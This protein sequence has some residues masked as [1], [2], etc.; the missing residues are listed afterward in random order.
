MEHLLLSFNVIFP[1]FLLMALGY[2]I[3]RTGLTNAVTLDQMNDVS[4]KVFFPVLLFNSI[5]HTD[6][7]GA[8]QP[9]LFLFGVGSVLLEFF[10]LMLIIPRIEKDNRKRGVLVQGIFRSNF[11]IFG[12]PIS[13]ALCGDDNIGPVSLLVAIIVPIYNAFSILLLEYFRGGKVQWKTILLN[14][15]KNPFIIGAACGAAALLLRLQLPEFLDSV[16]G[17]IADLTTPLALILLG[18]SFRFADVRPQPQ[19]DPDRCSRET[20]YYPAALHPN[21]YLGGIPQCGAHCAD[22]HDRGACSRLFL[23]NGRENGRRSDPGRTACR[24]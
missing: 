10:A 4:F 12:M 24:L 7:Q 14:V 11:V 5:Y 22:S 15:L 17:N 21:L 9:K 8:F 23:Y 19:A 16:I 3:K 18:A 6:L 2:V 20:D 1:I 13:I